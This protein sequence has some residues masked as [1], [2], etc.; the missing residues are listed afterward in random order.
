MKMALALLAIVP[1]MA[2]SGCGDPSPRP[3]TV[4]ARPSAQLLVVL[5]P[6]CW[7]DNNAP[8]LDFVDR[9]NSFTFYVRK[10]FTKFLSL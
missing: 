7:L 9:C 8:R 5:T 6:P 1:V 3:A 10:H 4:V 2:F